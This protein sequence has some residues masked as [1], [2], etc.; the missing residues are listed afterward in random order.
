MVGL[1]I[2]SGLILLSGITIGDIISLAVLAKSL[3]GWIGEKD[4]FDILKVAC[5]SIFQWKRRRF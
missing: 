2:A 5:F 4:A 3:I 1:L